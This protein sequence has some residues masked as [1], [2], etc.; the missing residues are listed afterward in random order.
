MRKLLRSLGESFADLAFRYLYWI[1]AVSAMISPT[2]LVAF[3]AATY[4]DADAALAQQ[5]VRPRRVFLPKRYALIFSSL[6]NGTT[7]TGQIQI[8]A[9]G[10]F[11]MTRITFA[12][13]NTNAAQT[14][15]TLIVPELR[16]QIQDSGTDEL[17]ANQA[18]DISSMASL[19]AFPN[20]DEDEPYPRI[21]SGRSTLTLTLT[22]AEAAN[23]Y[24]VEVVLAGVLVKTYGGGM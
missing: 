21:I 7:Q 24:N 1:G 11:F 4:A 17:F 20:K 19:S 5:G 12:A 6:A 13:N 9:N 22:N 8:S 10:D 23:T 3:V 18:T 16:L 14:A 2:E 15:S